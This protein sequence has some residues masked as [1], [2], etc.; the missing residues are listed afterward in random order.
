MR[1]LEPLFSCIIEG[2][3]TAVEQQLLANPAFV[4]RSVGDAQFFPEILHWIY[5]GDTPLHAAAAAHQPEIATLLV[6]AGADPRSAKNHRCGQ[7]LHYACDGRITAPGWSAVR[8]VKTIRVL[9]EAG[10]DIHAPDANGA[11]G[12]H[13]A[14]R[15]RSAAAVKFLL[16]A[17]ADPALRNKPGST[18]F[19][20]A[21]QNTGRSESG[22]DQAKAAQRE[23]IQTFLEYG[24]NPSVKDSRG[25]SV[26]DWAKSDWIRKM[27]E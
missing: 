14:V 26:R 21:V 3:S 4:S 27:L 18:P 25:K 24:A 1:E 23:I 16:E 15:T 5:T 6:A 7:P 10:A 2:N 13:R 17:G 22:T 11:T 20:L 9:L 12:L 8:Q 19:H